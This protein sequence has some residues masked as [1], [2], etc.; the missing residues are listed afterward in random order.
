[1]V[2]PWIVATLVTIAGVAVTSTG[3]YF[4][5]RKPC[6][7]QL[8]ATVIASPITQ[9]LLEN[10]ARA[11]AEEQ[12]VVGGRCAVVDIESAES[13]AFIDTL[14]QQWNPKSGGAPPDVWIPDS[15]AWLR[16]AT[17][18]PVIARMM[19]EQQPSVARSVSVSAMPAPM[20]EAIGW[21]KTPA[22]WNSL[23][24][25]VAPA[26]WAR[27]GKPEWG[28]VRLGMSDPTKTTAGLLA[29]V[30]MAGADASGNPSAAGLATVGRLRQTRTVFTSSTDD[31]FSDLNKAD[32][33]GADAVLSY[34]SAF[35]ALETDVVN[36][37]LNNPTVP[38]V[39]VYPTD[40]GIDADNPY[41]VLKAP[42]ADA[43]RQRVAEQF[44]TFLR[45]PDG[46]KAY[47]SVGYRDAKRTASRDLTADN[48]VTPKVSTPV[49]ATPPPDAVARIL[50]AWTG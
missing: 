42:W 3:F 35:P 12:P 40:G 48:G 47:Q 39:A 32:R 6:S 1:V 37:N 5:T 46:R 19:P 44:G 13:A 16:R 23:I 10:V 50:T 43:A 36:Y 7:G 14:G 38:L 15:T 22:T 30:N 11:W 29:L 28:P 9:S 25:E 26:G 24:N 17:V 21:P 2:A 45:S 41:L 18:N 49:R 27:Y 34:V 4:L 33:Q 31:I 8:T 20:A